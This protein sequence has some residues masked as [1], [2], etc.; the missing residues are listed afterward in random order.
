MGRLEAFSDAVF[1]IVLTL[2]VLD[3]L[4]RGAQSPQQ[5]LA[6]WPTYLAFL[7]AFLT[8]GIVW[9]NHTQAMSRI[10]SANPIVLTLNL[11]LLL[12]ASLVPW[13]TALISAALEDGDRAD[14]IA[15]IFVFAIVT[16][17]ISVPWL[18]LDLYLL[19][20]P[21]LLSSEQD[22][23][24]MRAHARI[25]IAT[26]IGAAVSIALAFVSPLASLVLYLVIEATFIVLRLRDMGQVVSPK[27][28]LE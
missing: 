7:A 4:P 16:T 5:L 10:R 15:A 27:S 21:Q 28:E 6:N 24:W 23:S 2:L 12:G 9:L 25:S 22:V 3:L 20:H 19:R 17:L 26:L 1:A 11:G 8:I 13:P 14:Q 18:A